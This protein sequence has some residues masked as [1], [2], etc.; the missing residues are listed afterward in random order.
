MIITITLNP[1]F[2]RTLYLGQ[3]LVP[4]KL[5]RA[6]SSRIEPG[7]NGINVSRT[8]K[9]LGGNSVAL[10][11]CAGAI[12]RTMKDMLTSADIH[13]DFVDVAGQLRVNV[14]IIDPQGG[15]T[16]INE[17]GTPITDADF[18]RLLDRVTNYTAEGNIFVLSGSAPPNF[19]L[20]HYRKLCRTIKKN[21]CKLIVDAKGDFLLE[22]IKCEAD[23]I[24][25]NIYE[26]AAAVNGKPETDPEKIL[27]SACRLLDMGA[28]AVCVSMG[29]EGAVFAA[30]YEQEALY[31]DTSPKIF[32][33]GA[34]GTG[35]AMVG[36]LADAINR[37]LKFEELARHVVA[38]GRAASKLPGTQKPSLLEVYQVYETTRVYIL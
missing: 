17:S 12:G 7:G 1:A 2:D 5:N 33:E 27:I 22:A 23:Y 30:G 36:A 10:G 25:P 35:D 15:H 8:I 21:G 37:G 13:H 16:E 31:V 14:Q 3:P 6:V 19:P 24:K 34:V 29:Q 18:Q 11:F 9:A 20:K 4:G 26:L 38:A 28:K 32:D